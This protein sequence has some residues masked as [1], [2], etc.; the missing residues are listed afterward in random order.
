MK[1]SFV[2]MAEGFEEIEALTIVDMLRRASMPVCMVSIS[3]E[4]DVEGAHGVT[5]IADEIISEAD[6]SDAEWLILPGGMPGA[7]NLNACA[8]LI[9]ILKAQNEAKGNIAAICA[10]PFILGEHGMLQG[11]NATCYPGFEDRLKG[12]NYTGAPV[13]RDGNIITG[14]GPAQAIS[15]SAAIIEK[16]LGAPTSRRVLEGMMRN[17]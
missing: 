10:A 17:N 4:Y 3:D 13:E 1:K 9:S 16:S 6:F 7:A 14:N 5:V 12:A 2:F 15:F 11:K 8:P